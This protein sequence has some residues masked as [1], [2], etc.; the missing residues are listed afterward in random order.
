MVLMEIIIHL[1]QMGSFNTVD[2]N[3]SG[4]ESESETDVQSTQ[5]PKYDRPRY[6]PRVVDRRV[7]NRKVDNVNRRKVGHRRSP[8]PSPFRHVTRLPYSVNKHAEEFQKKPVNSKS[9]HRS[10]RPNDASHTQN[11]KQGYRYS[12]SPVRPR[13]DKQKESLVFTRKD[14]PPAWFENVSDTDV[15]DYPKPE[16]TRHRH[17]GYDNDYEA[18]RRKQKYPP[19]IRHI[20][21]NTEYADSDIYDFTKYGPQMSKISQKQDNS[22]PHGFHSYEYNQTNS[23]RKHKDPKP[24]DGCKIEWCDYL[25]HFLSVAE[26]NCWSKYDMTKQLKLAFDGPAIKYLSEFSPSVLNNFDLMVQELFRKH[27][28]AERAAA[29]KIEFKNRNRETNE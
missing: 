17:K 5:L 25:Q 3:Y 22:Y 14:L 10:C 2:E 8:S 28:P 7:R 15:N 20:P 29:W 26:Y 24:F 4:D 6:R 21:Q 18:N 23:K 27:D 11:L 16:S 9:L 13:T 19:Q 12:P 1:S